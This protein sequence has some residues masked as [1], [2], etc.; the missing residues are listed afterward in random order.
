M[1]GGLC[2]LVDDKICLGIIKEDLMVRVDPEKQDEFLQKKGFRIMDF[3]HRPMKGY[4][5]VEQEGVDMDAD[6][7][8]W[9]KRSLEFNPTPKN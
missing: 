9:I 6:F 3:T 2:F 5:Y 1:F 4:L 7:D 8:K